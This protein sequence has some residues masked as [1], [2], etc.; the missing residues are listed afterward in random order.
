MIEARFARRTEIQRP[1]KVQFHDRH[2][3]QHLGMAFESILCNANKRYHP[4]TGALLG[5]ELEKWKRPQL[6]WSVGHGGVILSYLYFSF[7]LIHF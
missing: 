5:F 6:L 4:V 7:T 2:L 3:I 1:V